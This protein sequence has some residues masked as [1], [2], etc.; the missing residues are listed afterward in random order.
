MLLLLGLLAC[1]GLWWLSK[2]PGGLGAIFAAF[3]R[4][5]LAGWAA[6]AAAGFLLLHGNLPLAALLGIGGCGAWR[7]RRAWAD[8]CAA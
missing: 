7:D 3:P 2:K 6:L 8:A 1:F 5:R 4:H